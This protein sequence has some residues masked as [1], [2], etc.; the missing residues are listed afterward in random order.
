MRHEVGPKVETCKQEYTTRMCG[1]TAAR[2]P[3]KPSAKILFQSHCRIPF[4]A[5]TTNVGRLCAQICAHVSKLKCP[6]PSLV[7]PLSHRLADGE[8]ETPAESRHEQTK[9]LTNGSTNTSINTERIPASTHR[10]AKENALHER[11]SEPSG[12]L[13]K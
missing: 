7:A 10:T 5:I 13:G 2:L 3:C 8:S 1:V 4:F 11:T 12:S 6:F 9:H